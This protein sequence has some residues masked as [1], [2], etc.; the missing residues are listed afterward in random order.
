LCAAEALSKVAR[1]ARKAAG[2]KAVLEV[3]PEDARVAI[4]RPETAE[5]CAALTAAARTTH[6]ATA[7][8]QRS[9]EKS[10]L[11]STAASQGTSAVTA[12]SLRHSRLMGGET[13]D[14]TLISTAT[15]KPVP[16]KL[17]PP[18]SEI[19]TG[20]V[21]AL[22]LTPTAFKGSIE[23]LSGCLLETCPSEPPK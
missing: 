1:K 10:D 3:A 13:Q 20:L 15:R 22:S 12:D 8:S 17:I 2:G 21:G 23:A 4:L 14:V 16:V 11:A 9:R 7:E 19:L 5:T 6:G 18:T